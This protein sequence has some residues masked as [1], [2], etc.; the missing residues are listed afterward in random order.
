MCQP[1]FRASHNTELAVV[2]VVDEIRM[3]LDGSE[4]WLVWEL[5]LIE[6][7]RKLFCL[8]GGIGLSRAVFNWFASSGRKFF[9]EL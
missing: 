6:S 7:I 2:K 1:N 5:L 9:I 8:D 3:T 4:S